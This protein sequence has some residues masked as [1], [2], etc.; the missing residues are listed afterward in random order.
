MANDFFSP[1]TVHEPINTSLMNMTAEAAPDVLDEG[2]LYLRPALNQQI[3]SEL[4]NHF[5]AEDYKL[6]RSIEDSHNQ[7]KTVEYTDKTPIAKER[8]NK[9][10]KYSDLTIKKIADS[11]KERGVDPNTA[12]ALSLVETG[13][14]NAS[15]GLYSRNPLHMN[16]VAAMPNKAE[17][18]PYVLGSVKLAYPDDVT[19][20][21]ISHLAGLIKRAKGDVNLALKMYNG[22][23]DS[24]YNKETPY[25]KK[26]MMYRD[27]IAR[28]EAM[29]RIIK[30]K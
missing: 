22:M 17:I 10:G 14:G 26:V 20:V 2:S 1:Y 24:G 11:A 30:G 12:V 23:G 27:D 21:S 16:D 6:K 25:A 7:T 3:Q 8:N 9:S 4:Y 5:N 28:N 19:D 15:G 13:L 29:Q 18:D